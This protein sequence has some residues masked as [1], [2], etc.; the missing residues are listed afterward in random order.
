MRDGE[1]ERD[2]WVCRGEL[3][4]F[5]SFLIEQGLPGGG[6]GGKGGDR[7]YCGLRALLQMLLQSVK[8]ASLSLSLCLTLSLF[9]SLHLLLSHSLSAPDA[10]RVKVR[11]CVRACVLAGVNA[12]CGR[13]RE[14]TDALDRG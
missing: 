12:V 2:E 5:G 9:F 4:R 11:A 7:P 3:G 13:E 14:R 8:G 6:A 10:S 1:R